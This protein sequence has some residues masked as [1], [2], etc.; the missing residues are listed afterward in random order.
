MNKTKSIYFLSA[1][2][3]IIGCY[4]L[5]LSYSLFVQTEEREIVESTVPS[6]S[7]ELSIHGLTLKE[8][9]EYI[10]KETITNTG[11][12]SMNYS[13][14][15]IGSDYE[16][17][18]IDK[19]SNLLLGTLEPNKSSDVYLYIKNTKEEDNEINFEVLKN[20]T[21]LNNNLTS[22]IDNT[23]LYTPKKTL[24]PYS[25]KENTIEYYIINNY[26]KD[27]EVEEAVLTNEEL[28]N[29]TLKEDKLLLPLINYDIVSDEGNLN[30]T[31]DNEGTSYYFNNIAEDNYVKINGILWRIVRINGNGTIRL[32]SNEVIDNYSYTESDTN[33]EYK[34]VLEDK[35][36]KWYEENLIEFEDILSDEVFCI[37]D[38]KELNV[39]SNLECS[40]ENVYKVDNKLLKYPIGLLEAEEVSLI[41][42]DGYLKDVNLWT[43]STYKSKEAFI[44][45]D[46]ALT[47]SKINEE[48]EIRP[49]INI[50]SD[51]IINDGSG[52]MEDPYSI[53]LEENQE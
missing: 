7:S 17:K 12:V 16:I 39:N 52:T 1:V 29:L 45:K 48:Y 42:H 28:E 44:T 22:N 30:K 19:D 31:I 35:I 40:E 25:D 2:V 46:N 41:G 10:I 3:L 27:K 21:T 49:V 43:I 4:A 18:L 53:E 36:N 50:K 9:E 47:T 23:E 37:T 26:L 13:L 33:L 15:V 6:L 14:N 20:Y 5:N 38:Y 51:I 32:V 24:I 8:N 34:N 11:T